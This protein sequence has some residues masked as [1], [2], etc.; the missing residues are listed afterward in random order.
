[1]TKVTENAFLDL[2]SPQIP[3]P[4][5]EIIVKNIPIP[6]TIRKK[7][8]QREKNEATLQRVGCTPTVQNRRPMNNQQI[9]K[10]QK[11]KTTFCI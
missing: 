9:I 2:R 4:I 5:D 3:E 6:T 1:M 10:L 7:S 11:R 8:S